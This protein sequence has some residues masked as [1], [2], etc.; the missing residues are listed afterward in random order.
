MSEQVLT[1]QPSTFLAHPQGMLHELSLD[2]TQ[3]QEVS[4]NVSV[5]ANAARRLVRG[6]C[7]HRRLQ[8]SSD[9][10]G[11]GSSSSGCSQG[12]GRRHSGT[13]RQPQP[14]SELPPSYR[15]MSGLLHRS[16]FWAQLPLGSSA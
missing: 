15:D 6:G 10:R 16:S 7:G 14:T 1:V 3:N 2:I 4:Q 13:C 8:Q 11:E 12:V 5:F 9:Q